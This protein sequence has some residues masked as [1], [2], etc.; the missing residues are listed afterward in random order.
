MATVA[1]RMTQRALKM[2][3]NNIA[4]ESYTFRGVAIKAIPDFS[5]TQKDVLK[6]EPGTIPESV[7]KFEVCENQIIG[8][9]PT[10]GEYIYSPT[11]RY[12]I[13]AAD[14]KDSPSHT[15]ILLASG[16]KL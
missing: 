11:H 12:E 1:E 14:H 7:V 10:V 2:L 15:Y 8:D 3:H 9:A 16:S 4:G 5:L 13:F 6:F